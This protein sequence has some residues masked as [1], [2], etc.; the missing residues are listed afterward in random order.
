MA[1]QVEM[2]RA[3]YDRGI[4]WLKPLFSQTERQ[5]PSP[6]QEHDPYVEGL[7][8]YLQSRKRD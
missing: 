3:F 5:N 8:R 6:I 4:A 1:F 2:I 7:L